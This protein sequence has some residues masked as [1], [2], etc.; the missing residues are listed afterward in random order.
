MQ[1]VIDKGARAGK[2]REKG[3]EKWISKEHWICVNNERKTASIKIIKMMTTANDV[4]VADDAP[5][6]EKSG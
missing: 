2:E 3:Q 1:S 6:P 5:Q 4:H